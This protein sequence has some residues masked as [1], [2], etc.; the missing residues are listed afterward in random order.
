MRY[1][2]V[3]II[4]FTGFF[5]SNERKGLE[6][7]QTFK[8]PTDKII[9]YSLAGITPSGIQIAPNAAFN[10]PKA[11]NQ[12]GDLM[13]TCF[14]FFLIGSMLIMVLYHL[15]MFFVGR[16]DFSSLYFSIFVFL[17]SL[18][19]FATTDAIQ[20]LLPGWSELIIRKIKY[21][22]FYLAP[23]FFILF[24][25]FI[26]PKEVNTRL[27]K[28]FVIISIVFTSVVIFTPYTIF[29][30]TLLPYQSI[31]IFTG[32]III[33]WL[34]KAYRKK[35][36]GSGVFLLGSLIIFG[37][38]IYDLVHYMGGSE[39]KEI[40]PI[41]LFIFLLCQSYVLSVK[42]SRIIKKNHSLVEELDHKNKNLENLI[43][44]RTKE[45]L[46]QKNLLLSANKELEYQKQKI[47]ESGRDLEVINETVEKQKEEAEK[48][49]LNILPRNI[50]N[51]L[52]S[53]G[54][55]RAHSYPKA[56]VLFIDFVNF[57]QF[58][59][60]LDPNHL[61]DDLHYYFVNFDDVIKKYNL[62]KIKTIGDAYM[63]AGGITE[64][65][66]DESV[67]ATVCAAIE[68][69]EFMK[70]YGEE[71]LSFGE[72]YLESRIGIH[73]GPVIT[74][75]VGK[76]KFAF[77]MWGPTVNIAKRMESACQPGKINISEVTYKYIK[78]NFICSSRGLITVKHDK[79][80]KMYYV[81]G[82]KNTLKF[83][84]RDNLL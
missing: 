63:C 60:K 59:E 35:R 38:L 67:A 39:Q 75:V 37:T 47:I 1:T 6:N 28:S 40:F 7:I 22:S 48:L 27:Y 69:S 13:G 44:E 55:T 25:R 51:E 5:V 56:T 30:K 8:T 84:H 53:K 9:A 21:S 65:E 20:I 31:A 12:S 50:A 36:Q 64:D 2:V 32:I 16:K 70:E 66:N 18:R 52:R 24:L 34:I 46:Q 68:I 80:V 77:D 72:N 73:T 43:E 15:G 26:F 83:K 14:D 79:L 11:A 45:L 33:Y 82:I 58:A 61:L 54:K 3:I 17:I 74:G 4:F 62:E 10:T 76:S 42:Y 81:E 57:S 71:K 41:G 23:V 29:L 78:D 19:V 49:I